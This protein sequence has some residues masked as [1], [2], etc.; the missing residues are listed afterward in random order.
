MAKKAAKKSVE[1]II[2][3]SLPGFKK[4]SVQR[5]ARAAGDAKPALASNSLQQMQ[6]K[7]IREE[8]NKTRAVRAT[9]ASAKPRAH[10]HT[11]TYVPEGVSADQGGLSRTF[12][13]KG[14]K[15]VAE[16]G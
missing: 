12:V 8:G 6:M 10:A 13:V 14:K 4:A 11:V 3:Q 2:S 7:Y 9:R 5:K 1:Q 16:R 15:I